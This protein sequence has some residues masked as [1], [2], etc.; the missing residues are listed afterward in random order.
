M[1]FILGWEGDMKINKNFPNN[2]VL[3]V[4]LGG[5]MANPSPLFGCFHKYGWH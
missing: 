2:K 4:I 1:F 3:F 5:A